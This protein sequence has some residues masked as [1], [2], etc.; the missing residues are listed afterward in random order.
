MAI[1]YEKPRSCSGSARSE[2][3]SVAALT[4]VGCPAGSASGALRICRWLGRN[5]GLDRRSFG[6]R[7]HSRELR[8]ER[9]VPGVA[10]PAAHAQAIDARCMRRKSVSQM[11]R[12]TYR[13]QVV[14]RVL[15]RPDCRTRSALESVFSR[16]SFEPGLNALKTAGCVERNF[17]A[18]ETLHLAFGPGCSSI[19]TAHAGAQHSAAPERPCKQNWLGHRSF[20]FKAYAGSGAGRL[21]PQ[22]PVLEHMIDRGQQRCGDRAESFRRAAT[23]LEALAAETPVKSNDFWGW[24]N[25]GSSCGLPGDVASLTSV[26]LPGTFLM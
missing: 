11:A 3:P 10:S 14:E 1:G 2:S 23:A 8:P 5:N 20:C 26:F 22:T 19:A 25:R 12:E 24:G 7:P 17:C 6:L 18:F 15:N 21:Q 16:L 4:R 13:S 9:D